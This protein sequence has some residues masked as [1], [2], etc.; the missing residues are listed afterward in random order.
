MGEIMSVEIRKYRDSD[1]EKVT[2]IVVDNFGGEKVLGNCPD[3][4]NQ[5]VAVIEDNVVGFF[6][7]SNIYNVVRGFNYYL[8]DYV[9]V[10][11]KY[12]HMGIGSTMMKFI[13]NRAS[14]ANIKYIQLTSSDKRETAQQMYKKLGF[15]EVDTKLFRMVI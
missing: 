9:C 14:D 13:I 15:E 12:Q 5:F 6:V 1:Y 7:L 4:I 8:V 3:Y 2:N 10:D 11:K